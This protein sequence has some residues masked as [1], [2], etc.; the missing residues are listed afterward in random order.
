[1]AIEKV[2]SWRLEVRR[3][4]GQKVRRSEGQKVRSK[5]KRISDWMIKIRTLKS[6]LKLYIYFL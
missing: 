2:R 1:M 5:K 6:E 4:E 3:S